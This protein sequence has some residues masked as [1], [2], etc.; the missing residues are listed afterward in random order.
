[1]NDSTPSITTIFSNR[2]PWAK[3][4]PLELQYSINS[5]E[6][7]ITDMNNNHNNLNSQNQNVSKV[8][9]L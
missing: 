8:F 2:G 5:I 6:F 1:M 7:Y 3:L 9:I 4:F